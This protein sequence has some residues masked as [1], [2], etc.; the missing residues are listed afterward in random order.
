M[1]EPIIGGV[2]NNG[3][4][5]VDELIREISDELMKDGHQLVGLTQ[6]GGNTGAPSRCLG[7]QVT[8]LGIRRI[9]AEHTTK[10]ST[11]QTISIS[12]N[13]GEMATG[14]SLDTARLAEAAGIV[15]AAMH[16]ECD[17]MVLSRFGK[18]EAIGGGLIDCASH[19]VASGVPVLMAV[20]PKHLDA[21]RDY[22]GGLGV[23]L[24][25]NHDAVS[26]WCR[27]VISRDPAI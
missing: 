5:D 9:T 27:R 17:L 7:M 23:E 11:L 4:R 25:P 15:K 18:S 16:D 6:S 3:D 19:A 24:E 2:M 10:Q 12:Q 22:H 1:Q 14:C 8:F 20:S 26:S 21:W 13:L